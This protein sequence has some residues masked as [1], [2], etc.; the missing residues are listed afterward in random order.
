LGGTIFVAGG[1]NGTTLNLVEAYAPQA[2]SWTTMP[3]MPTA[4]D[5][6][7]AGVLGSVLYVIGG[8]NSSTIIFSANEFYDPN[9][10]SWSKAADMP[11]A[12]AAL[13]IAVVGGTIYAVGGGGTGG[14]LATV[15][16]Y[17]PATNSWTAKSPMPT[18]RSQLGVV[19]IGGTIY[20]VGGIGISGGSTIY[21]TLEAYDSATDTWKALASMPTPRYGTTAGILG[22][23]IYVLGGYGYASTYLGTVEVYDPATNGWSTIA[24]MP[25]ARYALA[26]VTVGGTLYA[27]GGI[28]QPGPDYVATAEAISPSAC[29]NSSATFLPASPSVGQWASVCLT[30]TNN[31]LVDAT[32]VSPALQ[33]N[34]GSGLLTVLNGPIPT[35]PVV[36]PAGTSVSFTW[37]CSVSGGGNVSFTATASGENIGNGSLLVTSSTRNASLLAGANLSTAVALASPTASLGQWISIRATVTNSGGVSALGAVPSLQ[38]TGGGSLLNVESGPLPPGPVSLAPGTATTFV[39]TYSVSG[40]GT[41]SVSVTATGTDSG[42]GLPVNGY[43]VLSVPLLPPAQLGAML[44]IAPSPAFVGN[45]ASVRLTVTNTGGVNATAVTPALAVNVGLGTLIGGPSPSGTLTITPGSATTFVWTYSVSGVGMVGFTATVTGLDS[46][47][48]YGLLAAAS[49]SATAIQPAK[50][51]GSLSLPSA[52]VYIGQ[53]VQ[54]RLTV[55][56][57]GDVNADGTTPALQFNAGGFL[58]TA[59]GSVNPAGPLV[60]LPGSA[61]TF[62]WVFTVTSSGTVNVTAAAL[63]TYTGS[64]RN[65]VGSAT[66]GFV[67]HQP[68]TLYGALNIVP[69]AT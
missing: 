30:V 64:T 67:T 17:D 2:N 32:D 29:L 60:I 31:G 36:L 4:R 44:A 20:A 21:G 51:V 45:W 39:W 13:G 59:Q 66:G 7:A 15:E 69:Y 25:T 5:W 63:A 65:I 68:A 10:N 8:D 61:T 14:Y 28:A 49:A 6:S 3:S 43:G 12:R 34:T 56:H 37:T 57:T 1:F 38:L 26:A 58:L 62:V 9:T 46:G 50:L 48:G 42:T 16:A 24:N 19:G 22:G 40:L 53:T 18:A 52:S 54:I 47:T 55:T 33:S 23:K 11:T 27:I 35:G 41:A